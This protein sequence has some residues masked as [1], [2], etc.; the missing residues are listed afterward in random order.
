MPAPKSIY[1][2]KVTLNDSK[3][4]I[5]RRFLVNENVTLSKLHDILQT[6]MGWTN[7]HLHHF[8]INGEFYSEPFD[9]DFGMMET[10]DGSRFKLNQFVNREGF[11]FRYEYDFG[12]SWLHDLVVEKILPAEKG[13][14]YPVCVAGKRACPPEDVG[15]VWGYEDFLKTISDPNHLEH[16]ET[17]RWV[18]GDFDPERFNISAINAGLQNPRRARINE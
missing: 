4:P 5:W 15:G 14:R 1:Q 3:P 18:G 12:D 11:K 2:I 8:I 9:D 7:S 6:V 16:E 10:K 17:L 13:A